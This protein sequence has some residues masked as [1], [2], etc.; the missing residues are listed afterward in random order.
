MKVR[1]L[2]LLAF[3]LALL[4]EPFSLIFPTNPVSAQSDVDALMDA[5]SPA[6]KVGQLFLITFDGRDVTP[7]GPVAQLI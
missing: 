4:L 2:L 6:E 5:M 3:A 1:R 7:D